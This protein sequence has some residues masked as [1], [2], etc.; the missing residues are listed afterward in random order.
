M[1]FAFV[2]AFTEVEL[3]VCCLE[4]QV[5]LVLPSKSKVLLSEVKL[6]ASLLKQGHRREGVRALPTHSRSHTWAV[7]S[8][9]ACTQR[10]EKT[11]VV[12]S[13]HHL[14]GGL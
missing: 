9:G 7:F 8:G 14:R 11:M 6:D 4:L 12:L 5:S 1:S 3:S 13:K 10:P 2:D